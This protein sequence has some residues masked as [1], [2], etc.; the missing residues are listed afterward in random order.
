[1]KSFTLLLLFL[2]SVSARIGDDEQQ[3]IFAFSDVQGFEAV[4]DEFIV[5]LPSGINPSG[6]L[7][8][9]LQSKQAEILGT[10]PN[11]IHQKTAFAVRMKLVALENALKRFPDALI[12]PNYVATAST[13]LQQQTS[14]PW[15][16][17]RIDQPTGVD[18]NYTYDSDANGSGVDIY[19]IDT[20]INS[21]HADF[22]G[23]VGESRN[24]VSRKR[25][26]D[27][28]DCNG[29]GTHVASTAAGTTYGVA[30]GAKVHAVRVLNCQGSGTTDA[31]LGALDWVI[32]RHTTGSKSVINMSL[33]FG[34]IVTS[35][36]KATKQAAD[37]GIVVVKAAGNSNKNACN[38][39][40][41]T[42]DAL[43]VGATTSS[44]ARASYS[45]YGTCVDLFAPGSS[46]TAAWI[47]ST[48]ATNIISGTSMSSPHV[49]GTA[50]LFISA[51]GTYD[52][53]YGA[54]QAV[55]AAILGKTVGD[56][57]QNPGTGSP[58]RLLQ[59]PVSK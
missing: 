24:F 55:V 21:K 59:T 37:K 39:S 16:L 29:H 1:M 26:T 44:D 8:G 56:V 42:A 49:A 34:G 17:D 19:I 3:S 30:K 25:P 58:N 13:N 47:G 33:G 23:R 48:T 41:I 54:S 20:G 12:E 45:N 7:K 11:A 27:W 53:S 35:V 14:A 10:F 15:G 43:V 51:S 28:E 4:P 9:Q 52:G 32:G 22:A 31:I 6:I 2:Y 57:V 38:Y 18:G 50:A 5:I 46:I 36:D 40:P